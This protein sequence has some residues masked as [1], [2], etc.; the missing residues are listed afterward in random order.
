MEATAQKCAHE[1]CTCSVDPGQKYCSSYCADAADRHETE[2]QCD[3]K[4]A[5]CSL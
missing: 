1:N 4:H 5:N 3:C 2:I